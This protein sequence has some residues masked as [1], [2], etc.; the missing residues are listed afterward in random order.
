MVLDILP[1]SPVS[2]TTHNHIASAGLFMTLAA[3]LWTT[4]LIAYRI[5]SASKHNSLNQAKPR[6][7]N[8]LEIIMQSA[9][10]Y[11]LALVTSAL[12]EAIPQNESN[13]WPLFKAAFYIGSILHAITVC[14]PRYYIILA[15]LI[16]IRVFH[17]P[18]W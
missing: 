10:I 4:I 16:M 12:L 3:T 6:F 17:L 1:S 9:F 11:S 5:Y 15:V 8:I 2:A 7:Y 14:R 13:V 18:S